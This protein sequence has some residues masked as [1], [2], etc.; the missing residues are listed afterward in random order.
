[1]NY[2]VKAQDDLICVLRE[3]T[4]NWYAVNINMKQV[5]NTSF[6]LAAFV[7]QSPRKFQVLKVNVLQKNLFQC[8]WRCVI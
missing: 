2:N 1:M 6:R 7:F 8:W 4:N 3:L 5:V